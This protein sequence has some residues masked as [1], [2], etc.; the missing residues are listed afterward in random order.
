[1]YVHPLD[2]YPEE[3]LNQLLASVPFYRQ[4]KQQDEAQYKLLMRYSRMVEYRVGEVIIE[5]GQQ[6]DW[7]FF[8]LKGRLAVYAGVKPLGIRRVNQIASGE[9]FGDLA[10]LLN[11][12]R[13]ATVIVDTSCKSALVFCTDF[14]V[15]GEILDFTRVHL[16]TK[17]LYFRNMVHGLRWKLETYRQ[18]FPAGAS[19][20]GRK[21]VK[22]YAG[23][24]GTQDE[25]LSLYEQAQTLALHL[26]AWNQEYTKTA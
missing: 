15:F 17:L 9:V 10:V 8:L 22:P 18:K 23:V 4:V 19:Q 24:T 25:L 1:M 11:H 6:D 13:A 16:N 14:A 5:A 7:L 12:K 21:G 26:L 3:A 2:L 20:L